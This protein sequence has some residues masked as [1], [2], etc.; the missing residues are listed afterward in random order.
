MPEKTWRTPE[1]LKDFLEKVNIWTLEDEK[2][3]IEMIKNGST[4]DEAIEYIKRHKSCEEL[5]ECPFCGATDLYIQQFDG[6]KFVRCRRC[7]ARG[8]M[9]EL[10][11]EDAANLW[12]TRVFPKWLRKKIEEM[13]K[14]C[15]NN[16]RY[17]GYAMQVIERVLS[18]TPDDKE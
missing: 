16:A 11:C 8:P 4:N 14:D 15:D 7:K 17:V 3:R 12:N 9:E 13:K 10:A 6:D 1:E 5:V 18:L 2:Q